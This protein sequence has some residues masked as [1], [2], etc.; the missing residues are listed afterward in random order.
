[1]KPTRDP[2]RLLDAGSD[3]PGYMRAALEAARDDGPTL[4]QLERLAGRLPPG[5]GSSPPPAPRG[6]SLAAPA[7]G[8]LS[9]AA[10]VGV[11]VALLGGGALWLVLGDS[12]PRA[13]PPQA[14]NTVD[15]AIVP[16]A[17]PPPTEPP[18]TEPP[19]AKPPP[20]EPPPPATSAVETSAHHLPTSASARAKAPAPARSAEEGESEI[21]LLQRAQDALGS[22]PARAL[23]ITNEHITRFPRGMLAQ[24]REVIAISALRAL[25]RTSEA[26]ARATRF[27][28]A[29]PRSAHRRRLEV[30]I[31]DISHKNAVG[32]PPTQ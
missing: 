19:P 24:E 31:G 22:S 25:G 13:P 15:L 21:R 1:M 12:P 23:Q 16:P 11:I 5:G 10:T 29:Y 30:L 2:V 32:T 4:E 18:P 14:A 8:V 27:L 9:K 6:P 17:G 7:R 26:R 3:A 28:A 20:T